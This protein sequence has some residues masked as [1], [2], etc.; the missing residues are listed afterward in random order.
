M[1]K[2]NVLVAALL[3]LKDK[4]LFASKDWVE[5]T[6]VNGLTWYCLPGTFKGI[7]L[8]N[9]PFLMCHMIIFFRV[10]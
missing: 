4:F 10:T 8:K 5:P 7:I 2:K 1:E 6:S 9:L 3:G